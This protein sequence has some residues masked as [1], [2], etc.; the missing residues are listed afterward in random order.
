MHPKPHT[1]QALHVA[2]SLDRVEFVHRLFERG[3]DPRRVQRA[4]ERVGER[5]RERAAR[6]IEQHQVCKYTQTVV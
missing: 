4:R 3:A 2:I 5:K 6:D 1:L